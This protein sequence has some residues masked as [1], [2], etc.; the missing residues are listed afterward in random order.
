MHS[1]RNPFLISGLSILAFIALLIFMSR[2]TSGV[3]EFGGVGLL[4]GLF[5]VFAILLI[6]AI[7]SFIVGVMRIAK[8]RF[9][10]NS[11]RTKNKNQ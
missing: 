5:P 3:G 8:E 7:T 2:A 11:S 4:F 10:A 9:L 1:S 6:T